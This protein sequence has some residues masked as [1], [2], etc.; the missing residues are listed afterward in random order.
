MSTTLVFNTSDWVPSPPVVD[1]FVLADIGVTTTQSEPGYI[2]GARVE[3]GT[4]GLAPVVINAVEDRTDGTLVLG[5]MCRGDTSFDSVD[6]VMLAFKNAAGQQRRIDIQPNWGDEPD[7]LPEVS[8]QGQAAVTAFV[9]AVGYG[10]ANPDPANPNAHLVEPQTP[11]IDPP[12]PPPAPQP[13]V[14]PGPAPDIHTN[15]PAQQGPTFYSRAGASGDWNL[16]T[17]PT[18]FEC[19]VRSW[20]PSV[21]MGSPTET[22]WSVE[23]RIP[24]SV[25]TGGAN[26]L[27]LGD[28][29]GVFIDV[30][31]AFRVADSSDPNDIFATNGWTQYRFPASAP[32]LPNTIDHTTDIPLS[33]FGRGLKGASVSQGE[34]VRIK[35]GSMGLGCRHGASTALQLSIS[36]SENNVIVT[37][38]EN[39]GVGVSGVVA[40]VRMANWG[41]GPPQFSSWQLAPG[42]TN[43]SLPITLA[44]G[45]PAPPS[46]MVEALN[47]WLAA[48]VPPEYAP[49]KHHQCMWVQL[50]APPSSTG[51][52]VVF[53][54]GSARRNMDFTGFS[55][56]ERPA[57]ISAVGYPKPGDGSDNQE[58]M[59]RTRCRKIVVSE[60]IGQKGLSEETIAIVG[61]AV[62]YAVENDMV[63]R[64]RIAG[65]ESHSHLSANARTTGSTFKDS[66]VYLWITEGLRRTHKTME[67]NGIKGEI[68]DNG[69]GDFS[70]AAFHN[71]ID[72]P[73]GW[74][75]SGPGLIKRGDGVYGIKVKDGKTATIQVKVGAG[76]EIKPGDSSDLPRTYPPGGNDDP[77]P[78]PD[79][80]PGSCFKQAMIV[81]LAIPTT[82][83]AI[84][85]MIA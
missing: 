61:G 25:A 38:V 23:L 17:V 78:K 68:W 18:G 47:P 48:N 33:S 9:T 39:T 72:D 85:Q 55:S 19:K 26:W 14:P 40:E 83:Y 20:K 64:D 69:P 60:L 10:A 56:E 21:A 74:Q 49:P 5:I 52:P 3:L 11:P 70:L 63:K 4:S 82:I 65:V 30:F 8:V 13:P 28:D 81:L 43:P 29:F 41:L 76:P 24:V 75:L 71:G 57:E 16:S 12:P 51:T 32:V 15:M 42:C 44:P 66:V 22:A 1:G 59:L 27:D 84:S 62:Q 37:Q 34:G 73:M 31:R 35:G 2:N 54:Q 36:K 79:P 6:M 46:A 45:T 50:K 80:K 58:F 77:G 67:L 53:T 7:P